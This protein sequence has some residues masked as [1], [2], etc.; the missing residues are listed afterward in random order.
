MWRSAVLVACSVVASLLVLELGLRLV[1]LGPKGLVEWPNLVREARVSIRA[2]SGARAQPHERLGF[3][4]LANYRSA[5]FNIDARGFRVSPAPAGLALKE[6]PILA[7]GGSV[8]L[9]DEVADRDTYPSQLQAAIGRR[10]INAGMSAYGLD[11]MVLRAELVAAEE[12]PAAIVI[13][14]GADN[15]RRSEMSRVWGIEKP[16][17]QLVPDGHGGRLVERNIPVP[18]SPDPATTLDLSHRLFGRSLLVDFVLRR[19]QFQYEWT[20][21]HERVLP[22]GEG[23]RLSCPLFKRLAARVS[24]PVIVMIEYD[25][26]LWTDPPYM[27]E[28]RALTGLVLR[29]AREAGFATYDL[30]DVLDGP[31]RAGKRDALFAW[32]NHPTPAGHALTV[33]AVRALLAKA[34]VE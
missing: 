33:A 32:G 28:Q 31:M 19:L 1:L 24:A 3:V 10:V 6:P 15:L 30:F 21:D 26:Y 27:K 29:C 17:F 18:P 11:Q 25:P 34:G 4:G 13:S 7:I 14:L 23:A 5:D 9:G 2:Y 20:L 12:N 22:R 16:W 8:T